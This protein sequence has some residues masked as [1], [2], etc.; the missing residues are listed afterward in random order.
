MLARFG[1]LLP[2]LSRGNLHVLLL[3]RVNHVGSRK[4]VMFQSRGIEPNAHTV[5]FAGSDED[6]PD[7]FEPCKRVLDAYVG[8]HYC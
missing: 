7:P 6:V 1:R 4:A 2:D 3:E 5:V 8:I